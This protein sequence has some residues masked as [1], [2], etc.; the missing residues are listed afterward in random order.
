LRRSNKI[1][2]CLNSIQKE[3]LPE[4]E[5]PNAYAERGSL[6]QRR[7]GKRGRDLQKRVSKP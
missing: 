7:A 6:K 2:P 3:Y 1:Y 4:K 5:K